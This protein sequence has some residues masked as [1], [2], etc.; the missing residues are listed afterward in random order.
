VKPIDLRDFHGIPGPGE[1]RVVPTE[2]NQALLQQMTLALKE[3]MDRGAVATALDAL[4]QEHGFAV[5]RAET[6][7]SLI[8]NFDQ[9]FED[10]LKELCDLL[11]LGN[12]RFEGKA[13]QNLS[14][15]NMDADVGG[16]SR[17]LGKLNEDGACCLLLKAISGALTNESHRLLRSV[18]GVL[19]I[20]GIHCQKRSE[21]ASA[22]DDPQIAHVDHVANPMPHGRPYDNVSEA[23]LK[24]FADPRVPVRSLLC[25]MEH[26]EGINLAIYPG[27]HDLAR[28]CELLYT[29]HYLQLQQEALKRGITEANF[30]PIWTRIQDTLLK[31]RFP[32]RMPAQ[33]TTVPTRCGDLIV[34][35]GNQVHY[36]LGHAGH[37]LF[38][39]TVLDEYSDPSLQNGFIH[40]H[41]S[42]CIVDQSSVYAGMRGLCLPDSVAVPWE[43]MLAHFTKQLVAAWSTIKTVETRNRNDLFK[44]LLHSVLKMLDTD[45][46]S[47]SRPDASQTA[48]KIS[49]VLGLKLN[50]RCNERRPLFLLVEHRL[51]DEKG[52]G[53]DRY[54]LN[55]AAIRNAMFI[56]RI[57]DRTRRREY[58]ADSHGAWPQH[59]GRGCVL[60]NYTICFSVM[61]FEGEP[62]ERILFESW[63]D[64][65]ELAEENRLG[66]QALFRGLE[67]LWEVGFRFCYFH[68]DMLVFVDG[69]IKLVMAGY[70]YL[71][72]S[73]A[74]MSNGGVGTPKSMVLGGRRSSSYHVGKRLPASVDGAYVRRRSNLM[75]ETEEDGQEGDR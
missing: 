12:G 69:K 28:H 15:T 5:V 60:D 22:H 59:A 55:S 25:N 19:Q 63:D 65:R 54:M 67:D 50:E 32:E 21:Y 61:E 37:R 31:A 49:N 23:N 72:Q 36:G 20:S 58:V 62:L 74:T 45:K 2:I 51:S 10:A 38:G 40:V 3:I 42:I 68:S 43:K 75:A 14:K 24:C 9:M 34:L 18:E 41:S 57:T 17:T 46:L 1:V 26:G 30:Q 6:L 8:P 48:L 70:G 44:K 71:G 33:S 13:F 7:R 66:F 73:E 52:V 35:A 11:S 29:R 4:I 27:S 39:S 53:V 56:P 64:R 16:G 47:R